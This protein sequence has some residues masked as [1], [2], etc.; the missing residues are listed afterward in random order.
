[1]SKCTQLSFE[2]RH[3]VVPIESESYEATIVQNEFSNVCS[4]MLSCGYQNMSSISDH[5]NKESLIARDM[6]CP[7]RSTSDLSLQS[8]GV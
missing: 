8:V 5:M 7:N 3:C 2:V 1:M 6:R 4:Q